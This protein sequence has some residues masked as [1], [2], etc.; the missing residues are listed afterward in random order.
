MQGKA[1]I[2]SLLITST[3]ATN[4]LSRFFDA[5]APQDLIYENL[6]IDSIEENN[7]G[8]LFDKAFVQ[9][10][11]LKLREEFMYFVPEKVERRDCR[12]L[13]QK[14]TIWV[15][16]KSYLQKSVCTVLIPLNTVALFHDDS[17]DYPHLHKKF[18]ASALKHN[19]CVE[20]K[21]EETFEK[22]IFTNEEV[23][24]LTAEYVNNVLTL[25]KVNELSIPKAD[26]KILNDYIT[27]E[28]GDMVNSVKKIEDLNEE[29]E[30]ALIEALFSDI[31][32]EQAKEILKKPDMQAELAKL[33]AESSE[34]KGVQATLEESNETVAEEEDPNKKY[35]TPS[36]IGETA[37]YC[38]ESEFKRVVDLYNAMASIQIVKSIQVWTQN[39]AECVIGH[40]NKQ[41]KA[42]IRINSVVCLFNLVIAP[43]TNKA[44][45]I[46]SETVGL[47]SCHEQM[48]VM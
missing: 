29:T 12:A 32:E 47:T 17:E 14:D 42:V 38:N 23:E 6:L 11:K 39:V 35:L 22:S 15:R 27:E 48:N 21:K 4:K 40:D 36:Q 13:A 43:E 18:V 24:L 26:K 28:N 20:N 10:K 44:Q 25:E 3:I 2:I 46:K 45:L 33:Q 34:H 5:P 8:D 19:K 31:P 9:F 7:C 1:I 41:V 30:L 16:F 37:T